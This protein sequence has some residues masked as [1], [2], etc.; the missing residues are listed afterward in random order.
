LPV[1]RRVAV[2]PRAG[3]GRFAHHVTSV[4]PTSS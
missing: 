4:V 2:L 1:S 3:D